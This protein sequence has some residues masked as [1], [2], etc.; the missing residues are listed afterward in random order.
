MTGEMNTSE[1]GTND[2]FDA[3]SGSVVEIERTVPKDR[4]TQTKAS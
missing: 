1:A 2:G 4:R 3:D